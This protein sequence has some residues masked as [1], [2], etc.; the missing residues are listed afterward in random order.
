MW[1]RSRNRR[2][3][4][5]FS[6]IEA[7]VSMTILVIVMV[8]SMSLL[9]S[10]RS[11]ASRQQL[12]TEP[13]QTARRAIDYLAYHVEGAA[14]LNTKRNNPLAL[15]TWYI[16]KNVTTQATY[17]NLTGLETG[18]G[19]IGTGGLYTNFGDVGTD[20]LT[21]AVP[22]NPMALPVATWVGGQHAANLYVDFRAGCPVDAYNLQ[23]FKQITG[24]TGS[25]GGVMVLVDANG[26][27]VFYQIT[28]YQG[29]DC[30]KVV[31]PFDPNNPVDVIHVVNNP[32]GSGFIDPPG[33]QP[34]LTKPITMSG[35]VGFL[36]FRVRT[37]T[38]AAGKPTGPPNL[39]QRIGLFDPTTDNPGAAFAPIVEG[40][41]DFQVA[42]LYASSPG[43]GTL[44]FNDG[45]TPIPATVAAAATMGVPPQAGSKDPPTPYDITNVIGLRV[46]TTGRSGEL[47]LV[48]L[49]Q[50]AN[51]G[52]GATHFRPRAEDHPQGSNDV[53]TS[54]SGGLGVY[55]HN[56]MTTT[57]MLRNRMLGN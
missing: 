2:I 25:A 26:N 20:I 14:D 13:R 50:K 41:E 24:D 55:D 46:T 36:S 21:V 10:M 57:L 40:I 3:R 8:F 43:G 35:G 42:Y 29:S 28:G 47:P 56:R 48:A 6:L 34:S 51:T 30:S 44:I 7:L 33:G 1:P 12:F 17:N 45:T 5:G 9:F 32:G 39:E 38:D 27:Y 53:P 15:V 19:T 11:F 37:P 52:V 18:N 49:G 31:G 54:T 23:L 22:T 16:K 4:R